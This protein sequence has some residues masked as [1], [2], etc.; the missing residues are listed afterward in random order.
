[1]IEIFVL[2]TMG[3]S[4]ASTVR[5]KGHQPGPFVLLTVVL[6]IAG[7]F[8]GFFLARAILKLAMPTSPG[9]LLYGFALCGAGLGA[10]IA[11]WVAAKARPVFQPNELRLL[12]LWQ[13]G[14]EDA[15][16]PQALGFSEAQVASLTTGLFERFSGAKNRAEI[17]SW[18]ELQG[19]VLTQV[20]V[21]P[22]PGSTG[23]L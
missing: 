20:P 19:A 4:I 17:V 8:G 2:V 9:C 22:R 3:R 12:Q 13:Q 15:Q 18:A 14:V 11:Y 1:M 10:S 23:T 5:R 6:W 7:E 16:L 21:Q